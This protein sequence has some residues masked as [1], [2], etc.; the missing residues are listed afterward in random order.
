MSNLNI[1]SVIIALYFF[2]GGIS[3]VAGA[4]PSAA[5]L[6]DHHSIEYRFCP[7]VSV[8]KW[9]ATEKYWFAPN[10]WRSYG[11]TF[12]KSLESFLGAQWDGVNVGQVTCLYQGKP[13]GTFLV[14]LVSNGLYHAPQMNVN[15]QW[16]KPSPGFINCK[17]IDRQMCPLSP[18]YKKVSKDLIQ[19]ALDLKHD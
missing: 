2:I 7:P 5:P 3:S 15:N 12:T 17:S 19:E 4:A 6:E 13:K 16:S 1:L 10:G 8:F 11:V 14:K 9:N 18:V